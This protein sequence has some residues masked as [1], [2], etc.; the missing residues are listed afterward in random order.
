MKYMN[1][2]SARTDLLKILDALEERVAI[3][4]N[5]QPVAV[6]LDYDDY[7]ALRASQALARD[8]EQLAHVQATL[9]RVNRG[10]VQALDD[11]A[12]AELVARP[13]RAVRTR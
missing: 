11:V 4:K 10:D 1:A 13:H 3:T 2:T 6:L 9:D 8:G 5:G 7:R 12:D